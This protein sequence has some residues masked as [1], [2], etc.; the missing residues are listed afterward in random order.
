MCDSSDRL[1]FAVIPA[2]QFDGE[3]EIGQVAGRFFFA[4][5]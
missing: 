4:L 2:Q 1:R 5:S 3:S